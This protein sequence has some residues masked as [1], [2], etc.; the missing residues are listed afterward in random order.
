MLPV[1]HRPPAESLQ[2]GAALI[3]AI[4]IV[5]IASIVAT[6]IYYDSFLYM[7]RSSNMLLYDQ[8]RLYTLGAEDWAAD[9]LVRDLEDEPD[10]D[11]FGE[12]WAAT[13]P[14]LPIDGGTLM[15]ALEDQ[16]GRFNL[17][18]LI[19][20]EGEINEPVYEQFKR[21]LEVTGLNIQLADRVVD[22]L[23]IDQEAMFPD[24]AEDA[25][26][27]GLNV[28]YRTPNGPVT[29]ASELLAVEGFDRESFLALSPYVTALP[30]GSRVNINTASL[31]VMYA[32]VPE[33]SLADAEGL[34]ENRPD[35]GFA[36][37]E[38]FTS[39]AESADPL[40]LSTSS[41]FFRLTVRVTIG[42]LQLNMYSL[43]ARESSVVRP[44][45]RSYGSE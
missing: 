30:R 24:G 42:T 22:W 36:S 2:R 16:Q 18:N 44:L 33:I 28:P 15:G 26:Y 29:S 38:E 39:L 11:H 37:M 35:D 12:E 10:R 14:P 43:L 13:L 23:D 9:I 17:N 40:E 20:V 19:T 1:P 41:Q 27:S 3:T 32:I 6:S 4:L 45:L 7:K 5:A 25:L 31:P 34:I 21:L 8:A